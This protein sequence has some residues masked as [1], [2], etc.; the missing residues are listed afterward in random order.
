MKTKIIVSVVILK[1]KNILM[2]KEGSDDYFK[3]WYIPSGH[4][5][6]DERIL[7]A[8]KREF[9]EETGYK[10]RISSLTG[11]YCYTG[12]GNSKCIRFNFLG[13]I[14]GGHLGSDDEEILDIKWFPINKI[15][16]MKSDQLKRPKLVKE[17]I[18]DVETGNKYPMN[19]IHDVSL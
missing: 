4:L 17:I 18:K 14:V 5:E 12:R 1:G 7:D 8:A 13:K 9:F 2:V 15:K 6:R 3:K 10:V 11:V 16:M 19:M